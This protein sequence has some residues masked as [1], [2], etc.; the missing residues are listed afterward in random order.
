MKKHRHDALTWAGAEGFMLVSRMLHSQGR[1]SFSIAPYLG[2][3]YCTGRFGTCLYFRLRTTDCHVH[4]YF[5]CSWQRSRYGP[6]LT[7][8][9]CG[10]KTLREFQVFVVMKIQATV[11]WVMTSR[12][13][14]PTFGGPSFIC[15]E[16]GFSCFS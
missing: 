16:R 6:A 14:I 9:C 15:L 10:N 1:D 5:Q 11:F 2:C 8:T 7:L 12:G 3:I 13:T 4:S